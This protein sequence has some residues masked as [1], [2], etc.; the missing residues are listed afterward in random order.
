[1]KY[2]NTNALHNVINVLMVLVPAL[3]TFDWTPFFSDET[4]L[5]IVGG[6]GLLKICINVWRDGPGGLAAPQPPVRR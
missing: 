3:E 6:L 4:A 2:L 5:K 1:M